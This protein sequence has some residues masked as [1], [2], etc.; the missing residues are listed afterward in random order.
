MLN[1]FHTVEKQI[2]NYPFKLAGISVGHQMIWAAVWV[3]SWFLPVVASWLMG[4]QLKADMPT[5]L[6]RNQVNYWFL[7]IFAFFVSFLFGSVRFFGQSGWQQD[8]SDPTLWN[9]TVSYT[10]IDIE[11][12]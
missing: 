11:K 3:T 5:S 4:L 1:G 2:D 8:S 7:V 12:I 6:Y 9:G 10:R